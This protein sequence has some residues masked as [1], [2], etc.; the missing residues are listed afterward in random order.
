MPI[1]VPLAW[2]DLDDP[3]RL[4]EGWTVA[5]VGERIATVGDPLAPLLDRRQRLPTLR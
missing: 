1:V 3:D 4:A 2:P 5:T